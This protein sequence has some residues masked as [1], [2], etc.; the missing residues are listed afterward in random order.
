MPRQLHKVES[1]ETTA[2]TNRKPNRSEVLAKKNAATSDAKKRKSPE[3]SKAKKKKDSNEP[4]KK[5]TKKD[6]AKKPA[7]KKQKKDPNMPK[8]KKTSYMI[9]QCER[10]AM[11]KAKTPGIAFPLPSLLIACF[12]VFYF[13]YHYLC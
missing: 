9:F 11:L 3:P 10:Q 12:A 7:K 6:K 1:E 4:A 13:C 5:A 2:T 8:G